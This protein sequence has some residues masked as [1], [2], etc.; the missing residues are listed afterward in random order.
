MEATTPVRPS[1]LVVKPLSLFSG[2][3][4]LTDLQGGGGPLTMANFHPVSLLQDYKPSR[5][6]CAHSVDACKMNEIAT[7][8]FPNYSTYLN[9]KH[10]WKF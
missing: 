2:K 10:V 6:N 9:C 5:M 8:T 3:L 1:D 7:P 4:A